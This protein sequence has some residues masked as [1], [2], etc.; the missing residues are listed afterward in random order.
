MKTLYQAQVTSSGGRNGRVVSDDGVLQLPLSIPKGLGGPGGA[1][2]NPEQLFAAGYAACFDSAL[3]FVAGKRALK[4]TGTS[5]RATVAIGPRDG[6]GF[7]LSVELA[8]SIPELPRDVAQ[9]LVEQA[10]KV[11]PYSHAVR[12]NID[13]VLSLT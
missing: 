6:G 7:A 5:V 2:T 3:A 4:L 11:C 10:D 13:V 8:V 12:G 9:D 1:A